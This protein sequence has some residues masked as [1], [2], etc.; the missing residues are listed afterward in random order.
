MYV[1]I[2]FSPCLTL[3]GTTKYAAYE[4]Q[5][6]RINSCL[7]EH[8]TISVD[9]E[10]KLQRNFHPSWTR[11]FRCIDVP[12]NCGQG[13]SPL[14][15]MEWWYSLVE[16][17]GLRLSLPLDEWVD[18]AVSWVSWPHAKQRKQREEDKPMQLRQLALHST[19]LA[20]DHCWCLE[21]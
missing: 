13:A 11:A 8:K 4:N 7:L 15:Y 12:G 2:R 14:P 18:A 3:L 5:P 20:E 6:S 16:F 17:A 21:I 19:I 9:C 1:Q 10:H